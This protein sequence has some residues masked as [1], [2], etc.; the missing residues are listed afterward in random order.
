MQEGNKEHCCQGRLPLAVHDVPIIVNTKAL[1]AG[2]DVI[3]FSKADHDEEP[4]EPPAKRQ[5][6]AD[7][8]KAAGRG[9]GK[10]CK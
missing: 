8:G 7:K 6:G 4:S 3:L 10:R 5:K 1:H 9:K 2:D